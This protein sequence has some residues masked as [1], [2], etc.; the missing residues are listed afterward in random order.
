M[1]NILRHYRTMKEKSKLKKS[2][3]EYNRMEKQKKLTIQLMELLNKSDEKTDVIREIL[4]LIKKFTGFEAVGVR[5]KGN[6]DFPY[7]ETKGFP[8]KFVEAERYLCARNDKGEL[9]RDSKGK[10]VLECMC[11]NVILGKTNP[12]LPFFNKRGSFWT[13][14]TTKLLASAPEEYPQSFTRNRCSREGYESVA[15]IP[16]RAGR[17]IIGLLQLNDSRKDMF[18]TEI[19]SFFEDIGASI[20]VSFVR[21]QIVKALKLSEERYALAQ[22]AAN[23]GSWDWDI[24]TGALQWSETIESMFG[25]GRGEFRATYE[26]FLES[27]HPEDRQYVV[28]SVN[29]CLKKSKE[30]DIEHRIV[31]PNGQVRWV[32]EKGDVIRDK[33]KKA[34]RMLGVVQ[35]ITERKKMEEELR[36]KKEE[37][38]KWNRELQKRVEE[39]IIKL[40][41]VEELALVGKLSA[42]IVHEINN[43]LY[44]IS[45]YIELLSGEKDEELQKKHLNMISHGVGIIKSITGNLLDLSQINKLNMERVN[46]NKLLEETLSFSMPDIEKSGVKVSIKIQNDVPELYIDKNKIRQVFLNLITNAVESMPGGGHLGINSEFI[47]NKLSISFKDTGTGISKENLTHIFE[48]FFSDKKKKGKRGVGLGLFMASNIISLHKGEIRVESIDGKGSTFNVIL[49]I[50]P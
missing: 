32:S 23:I 12:S 10:P 37:I 35:D 34:V 16:L 6:E 30:Y 20:G 1:E 25:F 38:E 49:R 14:S 11:G 4:I 48:P 26:A 13:N 18:T 31:W 15:L 33:N 5:L 50:K 24:Q 27:V 46:I 2:E 21:K 8:A 40:K 36:L 41:E 7:Y 39:S 43:P 17:E 44:G 22:R 29:A 45:N 19:I 3:T 28:E 9:V 42:G 47:D